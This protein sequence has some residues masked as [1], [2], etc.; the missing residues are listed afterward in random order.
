MNSIS[1]LLILS[2]MASRINNVTEALA[3][4]ATACAFGAILEILKLL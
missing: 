3:V 2:L 1:L 4:V